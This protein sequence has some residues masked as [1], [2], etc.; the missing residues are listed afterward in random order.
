MRTPFEIVFVG[1]LE[2]LNAE[3]ARRVK[4]GWTCVHTLQKAG[5]EPVGTAIVVKQGRGPFGRFRRNRIA[6]LVGAG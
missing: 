2:N 6:F 1:P 5:S 4:Y 3:L